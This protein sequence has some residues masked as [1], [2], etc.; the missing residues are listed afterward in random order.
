MES[1][2]EVTHLLYRVPT[3]VQT[4]TFMSFTINVQERRTLKPLDILVSTPT[5][6]GIEAILHTAS[7][8][9][10]KTSQLE[11]NER[12]ASGKCMLQ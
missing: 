2:P 10:E 4:L 7:D 3:I 1:D 5:Y 12:A 6:L 11:V 8:T 9:D